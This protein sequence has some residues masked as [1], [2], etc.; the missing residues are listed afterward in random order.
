MCPSPISVFSV[1]PNGTCK[2]ERVAF[3]TIP[4]PRGA[5][6]NAMIRD[7]ANVS[8]RDLDP[9]KSLVSCRSTQAVCLDPPL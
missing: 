2:G 9:E 7:G 3:S 8:L 4:R 5:V 1:T 6:E